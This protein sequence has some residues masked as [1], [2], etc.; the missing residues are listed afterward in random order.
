MASLVA[1]SRPIAGGRFLTLKRVRNILLNRIERKL[2]R[3]RLRSRPLM[4]H[5]DLT[6]RCNARCV[7]CALSFY[8]VPESQMDME[9]YERASELFSTGVV[10]FLHGLGEPFLNKNIY[11]MTRLAKKH[12]VKVSTNS[13]GT[14]LNPANARRIVEQGIDVINISI[15][16]TD[17]KQFAEIRRQTTLDQALKAA[18]NLNDAKRELGLATPILG[19]AFVAMKRNVREL[20]KVVRLAKSLDARW[21][22]AKGVLPWTEVIQPE[23]LHNVPEEAIAVGQEAQAAAKDS[24]VVLTTSEEF[25]AESSGKEW[26]QT[27]KGIPCFE[28]W[29]TIRIKDNGDVAPCCISEH[30]MGN[31]KNSSLEEIWNGPEYTRFR[32]TM[33]AGQLPESCK[34][35]AI[36]WQTNHSGRYAKVLMTLVKARGVSGAA[37]DLKALLT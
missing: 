10:T 25:K 11:E 24:N 36:A 23:S 34:G 26:T 15:D 3:T 29:E 1:G 2:G 13:N 12:G 30:P 4:V 37:S 6:T 21:V 5:T 28:P 27:K 32:E 16:S 35:C 18:K 22:L 8:D 9:I 19:V 20:P 31:V 14:A 33:R 7:F 17:A